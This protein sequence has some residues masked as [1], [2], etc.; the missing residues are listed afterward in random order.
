MN[1]I[2]KK[3][4]N[5]LLD[6]YFEDREQ[7]EKICPHCGYCPHCGHRNYPWYPQYPFYYG[8]S[9]QILQVTWSCSAIQS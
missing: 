6:K 9:D 8:T 2:D 1:D 7:K 3:D 5:E 4:W